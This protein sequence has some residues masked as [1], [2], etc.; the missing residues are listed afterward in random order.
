MSIR[1]WVKKQ[2]FKKITIADALAE[3]AKEAWENNWAGQ[4][5]VAEE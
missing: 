4:V 5:M 3:L 1:S 2:H